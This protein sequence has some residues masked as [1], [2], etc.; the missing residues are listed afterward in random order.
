MT[1]SVSGMQEEAMIVL[2]NIKD[3]AHI[4]RETDTANWGDLQGYYY[5]YQGGTEST[6][7]SLRASSVWNPS[8]R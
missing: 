5:W 7:Y 4:D 3:R 2:G 8:R 1:L 6:S